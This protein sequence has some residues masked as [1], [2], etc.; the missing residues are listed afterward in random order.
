MLND[1]HLIVVAGENGKVIGQNS[2][3]RQK[4]GDGKGL[5][6]WDLMN[7]LQKTEKLPCRQGCV[8]EILGSSVNKARNTRIKQDGK[9]H[10][11]TC[12]PANGMVVC[13]LT[14]TLE[15]STDVSQYLSPREREVMQLLA[16]G[17]TTSSIAAQLQVNESTI[18]TH[19]ERMR[20]KLCVSTRAA[21]VAEGYRLGYLG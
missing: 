3:A 12:V 2:T 6:C 10:Q 19:I 8:L 21:V 15:D 4:L 5:Y 7:G 16:D 18:R 13:V 9:H 20:A 1:S 11:L 17:E 14:S